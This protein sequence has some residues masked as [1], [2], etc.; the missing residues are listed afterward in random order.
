MP[1]FLGGKSRAGDIALL[2]SPRFTS[3]KQH[4]KG[5]IFFQQSDY[6]QKR[7][8][9]KLISQTGYYHI[10]FS[11][12]GSTEVE[13]DREQQRSELTGKEVAKRNAEES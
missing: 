7:K 6:F 2:G 9:S 13:L 8:F 5:V 4:E 11:R 3:G 1:S 12:Q 10:M